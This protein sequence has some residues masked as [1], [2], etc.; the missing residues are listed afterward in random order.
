[1]S[2][3]PWAKPDLLICILLNVQAT[4]DPIVT[5]PAAAIPFVSAGDYLAKSLETR[6][7]VRRAT[8]SLLLIN[9]LFL[10]CSTD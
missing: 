7:A 10:L 5:L 1:M 9:P 2:S 8:Q 3:S 6:L 4:L